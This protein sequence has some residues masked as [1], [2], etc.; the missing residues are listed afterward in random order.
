LCLSSASST[1]A[2]LLQTPLAIT[3]DAVSSTRKEKEKEEKK[4]DAPHQ[5]QQYII[6]ILFL[7]L[8]F[9]SFV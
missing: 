8:L 4:R 5:L 2:A 6:S 7:L 1:T 3:M 9:L